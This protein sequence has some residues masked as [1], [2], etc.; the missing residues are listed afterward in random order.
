M[1]VVSSF[2]ASWRLLSIDCQG[3]FVVVNERCRRCRLEEIQKTGD[4]INQSIESLDLHNTSV[5]VVALWPF[6]A[7]FAT[8]L[9]QNPA[10]DLLTCRMR[11]ISLWQ[12]H[13][14]DFSY[15]RTVEN[16]SV[17]S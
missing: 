11:V 15:A 4:G 12:R 2:H 14:K 17:A 16:E 13:P 3:C 6:K 8:R 5:S 9:G 1:C 10:T 7:S